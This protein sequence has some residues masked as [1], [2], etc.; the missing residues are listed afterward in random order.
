MK[1]TFKLSDAI[2][3]SSKLVVSWF[4]LKLNFQIAGEEVVAVAD[5]EGHPVRA[6][7]VVTEMEATGN[8]IKHSI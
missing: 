2:I 5:M 8:H 1:R 7:T 4:D 6:D 3:W